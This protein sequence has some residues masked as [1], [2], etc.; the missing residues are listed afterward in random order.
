M[1]G[2][3]L[4]HVPSEVDRIISWSLGANRDNQNIRIHVAYYLSL[5]ASYCVIFVGFN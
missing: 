1:I 2:S 5:S 3:A 4:V